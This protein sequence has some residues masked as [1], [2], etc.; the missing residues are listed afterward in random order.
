MKVLVIEIFD[1]ETVPLFMG[2]SAEPQQ[3]TRDIAKLMA[4][5]LGLTKNS[6]AVSG[7]VKSYPIT[8][9]TNPTW[10]LSSARADNDAQSDRSGW[11]AV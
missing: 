6:L 9:I 3:I 7:H 8:L 1:L 11:P 10:D 5:V 2:D 4:E